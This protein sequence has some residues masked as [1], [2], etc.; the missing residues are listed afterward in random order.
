MKQLEIPFLQPSVR[1]L[2]VARIT[3][4]IEQRAEGEATQ[5]IVYIKIPTIK[6]LLK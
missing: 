4:R 1:E 6:H 2:V 3:R 5:N